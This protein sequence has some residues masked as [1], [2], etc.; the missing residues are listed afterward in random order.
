[1]KSGLVV[2]SVSDGPTSSHHPS[3]LL[4]QSVVHCDFFF[5]FDSGT[6]KLH[7]GV[8]QWPAGSPRVFLITDL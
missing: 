1:M 7:S 8:P 4:F 5:L 6:L 2:T 3:Q